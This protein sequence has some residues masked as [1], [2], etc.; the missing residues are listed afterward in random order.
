MIPGTPNILD[1]ILLYCPIRENVWLR[2]GE[3]DSLQVL[4]QEGFGLPLGLPIYFI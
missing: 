3:L 2:G 1:L 4:K